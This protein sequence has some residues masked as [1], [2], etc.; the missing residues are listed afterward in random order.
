MNFKIQNPIY[1]GWYADPEA[2]ISVEE[3]GGLEI[4]VSES[5]MGPFKALLDKPLVNEFY[6]GAQPIIRRRV[7]M[8][9]SVCALR[10]K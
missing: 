4:A 9:R 2:R 8:M 5:P 10:K 1:D 6:N 3:K 7:I